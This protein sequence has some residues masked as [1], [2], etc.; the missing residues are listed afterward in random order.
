[1]RV[2]GF[3]I[4]QDKSEESGTTL[5]PV[6][7]VPNFLS[8]AEKNK[9]SNW[10]L[11]AMWPTQFFA[12]NKKKSE[13][14]RR[15]RASFLG[16]AMNELFTADVLDAMF[17]GIAVDDPLNPGTLVRYCLE[18]Q[19]LILDHVEMTACARTLGSACS[20]SRAALD[21]FSQTAPLRKTSTERPL[22]L[23]V[24]AAE[25]AH[26]AATSDAQ[27]RRAKRLL[28]DALA[29]QRAAGLHPRSNPRWD[30]PGDDSYNFAWPKLHNVPQGVAKQILEQAMQLYAAVVVGSWA[31]EVARLEEWGRVWMTFGSA[32]RG[33][34]KTKGLSI[35]LRKKLGVVQTS[36][37]MATATDIEGVMSFLRLAFFSAL[38]AKGDDGKLANEAL[39]LFYC[40][41]DEAERV[42]PTESTLLRQRWLRR[43]LLNVGGSNHGWLRAAFPRLNVKT[44][45]FQ[46][47]GG[48]H[49]T[50]NPRENGKGHSDGRGEAKQ[51]DVK[52]ALRDASNRGP[53]AMKQVACAVE[54]RELVRRGQRTEAFINTLAVHAASCGEH[55]ALS[56][57][58]SQFDASPDATDERGE[59]ALA[60]ACAN[61]H[62]DCVTVPPPPPPA[63]RPSRAT[64]R[65]HRPPPIALL[66]RRCS[67]R[68]APTSTRRCSRRRRVACCAT[69]TP[70]CRRRRRTATRTAPPRR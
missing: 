26:A 42:R 66:R 41:V 16:E 61:G 63:P 11:V 35:V 28:R 34:A 5:Y 7:L 38:E 62:A 30:H 15:S 54:L 47:M 12:S 8:L 65:S 48:G 20:R 60:A 17:N 39:E 23:A 36:F 2:A 22:A 45:K 19:C 49:D 40:W 14:A 29:A 24:R 21:D 6:F 32:V 70:L 53:T 4:F 25:V 51:S 18:L 9:P 50:G 3:D 13:A 52:S 58:L 46:D 68:P 31:N 27:K 55:T 37:C 43:Q 44:R 59:S 69:S 10:V 67:S 33:K 56:R 64:R 1:M 57:L